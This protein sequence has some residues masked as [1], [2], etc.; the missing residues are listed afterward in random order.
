[1]IETWLKENGYKCYS[2]EGEA[3]Y[4]SIEKLDYPFKEV[5]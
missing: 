3:I 4:W 2:L 1:M 5:A